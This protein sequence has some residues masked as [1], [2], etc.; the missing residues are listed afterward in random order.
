MTRL[1]I[2]IV[3]HNSRRD[4]PALLASLTHSAPA[5]ASQIVV[6]DNASTDGTPA[7]VEAEWPEVRLV[8]TGANLGFAVASNIGIRQSQGEF[9]LLLNPDTIVPPGALDALVSTLDAHAEAAAVG[10]RLVDRHGHAELSF[11]AMLSPWTELW[12]KALV[13]GNER[14]LPLVTPLV[15]CMTRRPREVDWV[16]GACLLVRRTDLEAVGLLDERFFMYTED[17]DLCASLRARGRRI[18]FA[19]APEVVHLRGHVALGSDT[20]RHYRRSQIAFYQ[21]HHPRWTP[22]LTAYLKVRGR[23]PDNS[24]G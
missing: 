11:G 10:P 21:K 2:V 8:T 4:L 18:L 22:L 14:R 15:D 20:E 12:Q 24:D 6:V 23:L 5:V 19:G 16:S 13:R 17:V 1:A 3:S 9:I 7:Y